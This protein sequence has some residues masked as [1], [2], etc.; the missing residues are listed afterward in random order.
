[1][2]KITKRLTA[3]L[4]AVLMAVTLLPTQT[5]A[6][7]PDASGMFYAELYMR[8]PLY[9]D[10]DIDGIPTTGL[11][12]Q[13]D[14]VQTYATK[15]V[16]TPSAAAA[17]VREQFKARADEIV[18]NYTGFN[19][20]NGPY[21]ELDPEE[22][23][24]EYT[25]DEWNLLQN[26]ATHE[27]ILRQR[28]F[29]KYFEQLVYTILPEV[30]SHDAG[31]PTGGDYMYWQFLDWNVGVSYNS[32][33]GTY[34]LTFTFT[35]FTTKQQEQAVTTAVKSLMSSLNLTGKSEYEKIYAIYEWICGH[36][37]YDYPHLNDTSYLLQYSAYGALIDR[38]CVCQGYAVLLYRMALMAGL[39]ARLVTS[40]EH[41]WNIVNIGGLWYHV[42]STWD[43]GYDPAN[44][45]YFLVVNPTDKDHILDSEGES[46]VSQYPMAPFDYAN[47]PIG[48]DVNGSGSV[49]VTDVA[50]L[51]AYLLTGNT[52]GSALSDEVFPYVADVN[53]DGS[54]NVY[55]LQLLYETVCN[56]Q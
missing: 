16:A 37:V 21:A 43:A 32:N 2:R 8:N 47:P 36:V 54:I 18:F 26:G 25:E 56:G 24:E 3:L 33:K 44:W 12:D 49:D 7:E 5:W 39:D 9:A 1:M 23:K 15:S 14:D 53:G 17:Y 42:D 13:T 52:S 30:F 29:S 48:G 4:C 50:M 51:Y 34:T 35:Y 27:D 31:D 22:M 55:D 38:T 6:V 19:K 20:A 28:S 46:V 10:L 40:D 11:A 41:A 45:G